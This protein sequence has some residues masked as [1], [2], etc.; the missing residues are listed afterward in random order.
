MHVKAHAC[1]LYQTSGETGCSRMIDCCC[2]DLY[3]IA[4]APRELWTSLYPAPLSRRIVYTH[5][6]CMHARY[7]LFGVSIF[8][9]ALCTDTYLPLSFDN[10]SFSRTHAGPSSSALPDCKLHFYVMPPGTLRRTMVSLLSLN[11]MIDS[12][13]I[14]MQNVLIFRVRAVLV[15][16]RMFGVTLAQ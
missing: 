3:N 2:I 16:H 5:T 1:I 12:N 6:R 9:F 4:N 10:V 8:F 14:S 7:L 13:T 11:I 15:Y